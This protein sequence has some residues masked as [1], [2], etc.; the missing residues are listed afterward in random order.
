MNDN[1]H[2]NYYVMQSAHIALAK[3]HIYIYSSCDNIV[4]YTKTKV[5]VLCKIDYYITAFI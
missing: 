4:S 3:S 5:N 1:L 2:I